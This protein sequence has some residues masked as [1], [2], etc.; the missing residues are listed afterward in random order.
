MYFNLDFVVNVFFGHGGDYLLFNILLT[1]VESRRCTVSKRLS[2]YRYATF[3]RISRGF[4]PDGL[5]FRSF[6][7]LCLFTQ[8]SPKLNR[9][10]S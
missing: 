9:S 5:T 6:C 8:H 10:I 2:L 1:V 3:C 7:R 4:Q